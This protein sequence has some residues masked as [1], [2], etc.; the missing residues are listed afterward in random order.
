MFLKV[1]VSNIFLTVDYDLWYVK[2]HMEDVL[3]A[4]EPVNNKVKKRN[5]MHIQ[6]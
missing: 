1:I 6:F 4:M 3:S 2:D 5:S